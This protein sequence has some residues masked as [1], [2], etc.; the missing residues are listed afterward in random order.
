[1]DISCVST[2][3]IQ[4]KADVLGVF[5]LASSA[6]VANAAHF[7][8]ASLKKEYLAHIQ[9]IQFKAAYKKTALLFTHHKIPSFLVVFIGLGALQIKEEAIRDHLREASA[10]LVRRARQYRGKKVGIL[11]SPDLANAIND[12]GQGEAIAE[13]AYLGSYRFTKHKSKRKEESTNGDI[14]EIVVFKKTKEFSQGLQKGALESK[15]VLLARDLV[16]EP[17]GHMKPKD[18]LAAAKRIA[19]KSSRIT[20]E[21][22]GRAQLKKMGCGGI[23]GVAQGS[24]SEPYLIHLVYRSLKKPS[25][26]I[27]IVGKGITFD[28]GGLS[29]K[30]SQNMETMKNDMGGAAAVLGLFSILDELNPQVE[31]HGFIGTCENMLGGDALRPGDVLTIKNGKTVEVLNTD[32]EGRLVLADALSYAVEKKMDVI[33][34][35]ATLT[36][37]CMVGLGSDIAGLMSN[38]DAVCEGL[39]KAAQRAGEK[40][41]TLPLEKSYRK[42]LKSDIADLRNISTMP[43]GGAITAG[44]FLQEF[45]GKTPWAHFDI[46]GPVSSGRSVNA[47]T[48]KGASGFG[49]RT[50]AQFIDMNYIN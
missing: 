23:L 22:F 17:A 48:G 38:N 37:A 44:L 7:L 10:I 2:S 39:A 18:L 49:V 24:T 25:K 31:V 35:I 19:Q 11:L 8:P 14:Q 34:D 40:V 26:K 20:I 28:S 21:S 45:V 36:G 9:R 30:P 3:P 12:E 46:A 16:N 33:I 4:T 47:Y 6:S 42:T 50:L 13:G 27:G 5:V 1:M 41:W 32:A 29:I 43:Y 15:G